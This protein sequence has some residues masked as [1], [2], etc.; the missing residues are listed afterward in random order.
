MSRSKDLLREAIAARLP[1]YA[2]YDG[3]KRWLCPHT[4]GYKNGKLH[5]LAY[6]YAGESSSRPIVTPVVPSDGPPSQ[7]RC[8]VV[9]E[10]SDLAILEPGPWYTCQRHTRCQT[11]VDDVIIEVRAAG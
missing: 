2:V 4:L 3:R 8:I 5:L 1:V 7:W 11:C 10:L 6:Q 9:G